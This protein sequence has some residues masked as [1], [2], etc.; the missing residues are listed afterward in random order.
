MRKRGRI[1][2]WL[3]MAALLLTPA[4]LAELDWPEVEMTQGQTVALSGKLIQEQQETTG[5][6]VTY[7]ELDQ[8]LDIYMMFS[9]E[10]F[11]EALLDRVQVMSGSDLSALMDQHVL[12]MGEVMFGGD[13]DAYC[14]VV[15][16]N[17][18]VAESDS[19]ATIAAVEQAAPAENSAASVAYNVRATA[20]VNVR[21]GPG[22]GYADMGTLV[23]GEQVEYLEQSS[24][25]D[26]GVTWYQVQY[27]SNGVGWVSSV[28]AELVVSDGSTGVASTES[29]VT[30]N[31]VEATG[32]QSNLRSGPGLGYTD[33]GT[34][35]KGTT[36][37]YLGQS[38]VDERGVRW[39]YVNFN[40][41]TAWVSS[42]YTTLKSGSSSGNGHVWD[43][44]SRYVRATARVNVRSGPG[45]G[46]KDM[47]TLVKDEQVSYLGSASTDE[48]GVV[49]YKV[50]YYSYGT[51]WVSS[52]YSKLVSGGSAGVASTD[53]AVSGSYVEAT[54]GKSNVRSGPGLG[55]EDLGTIQRG[56]T[57][58]YLG[59]SSVDERGVR[60]YYVNYDGIVGWLSSRYTT[61]Y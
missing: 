26:R 2:V 36:A 20:S 28:Y 60:W 10:D 23:K 50:Q 8:P 19:F 53:S 1:L 56:E 52:V 58:T 41:T 4:A 11:S 30:G 51:G 13:D 27:Y 9:S 22:L 21:T 45:L 37:T 55:Y 33:V 54:G 40:G 24:R 38:S 46:Y 12:V 48:R 17:A 47:G 5:A 39:Y 31:Y 42:R 44:D 3:L 35:K 18:S 34:M 49:W 25:D 14:A 57:A 43:S 61:L 6:W 59:Q 15:L 7:L 16:R 29:N 32:G